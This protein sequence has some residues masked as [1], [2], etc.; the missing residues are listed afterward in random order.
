MPACVHNSVLNRFCIKSYSI[1]LGALLIC[2]IY[3]I[4]KPRQL[5]FTS[6]HQEITSGMQTRTLTRKD[7]WRA[8]APLE[9][10]HD[11]LESDSSCLVVRPYQNTLEVIEF[12]HHARGWM[13]EPEQIRH[14]IANE[15]TY[16]YQNRL[17]Q[18]HQVELSLYHSLHQDPI[19]I[20]AK[21][22]PFLQ[23]SAEEIV[24]SLHG[25]RPTFDAHHFTAT[26]H[27]PFKEHP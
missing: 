10:L 24:L 2:S 9:R 14:F 26:T 12:L 6:T 21:S 8:I 1:I 22:T 20:L 19:S 4:Y 5:S 11:R 18:A 15:G 13:Q 7:I 16:H 25:N 3:I 27:S 17:F 23:G